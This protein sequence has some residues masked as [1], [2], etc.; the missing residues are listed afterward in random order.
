MNKPLLLRTARRRHAFTLL[1]LLVVITVIGLLMGLLLPSVR[2]A[3]EAARRMQCSNNLKHLG[4]ALHNYHETHQHFPSAM[5]GT[6]T[7]EDPI[8]GNAY[9]VS[10]LVRLLPFLNQAALWDQIAAPMTVDDVTYPAMGPAPWIE[11][12]PPWQQTLPALMCPSSVEPSQRLGMTS[13]TFCIGDMGLGIHS[14][15]QLRGAFAPGINS[16]LSDIHDG[17]ANTIAMS[18]MAIGAAS[19]RN[20]KEFYAV[21]Q[22]SVYLSNP[23]LCL[24][25]V[26]D[27]VY[28][29]DV[30][31][32]KLGRGGCWADGA[33]G[34]SLVNTI[35]PPNSPSCATNG[36]IAVD[37][38]YSA[39][40]NHHGG[41]QVVMCD[42]SVHFFND[43]IDAGDQTHRA[44]ASDEMIDDASPSPFGVWGA[45]GTSSGADMTQRF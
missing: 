45:L 36:R 13:Y 37:G 9:R 11:S 21:D 10:G 28:K 19:A 29:S 23:S 33:A 16:R 7:D 40:S 43:K 22:R 6:G 2:T 17:T 34:P 1:E 31:L 32:G 18:E 12:Y 35:L 20:A 30:P 5:G 15:Q 39:S 44:I 14:A 38:L 42:G 24:E 3:R 8:Q 26:D 25:L 4:L 27:G 41:V